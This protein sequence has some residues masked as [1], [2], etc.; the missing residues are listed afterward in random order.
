M[1]WEKNPKRCYMCSKLF[2]KTIRPIPV[3]G[4]NCAPGYIC[5]ACY[6]ELFKRVKTREERN[7]KLKCA[8][9][10]EFGNEE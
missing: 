10:K 6:T 5:L 1:K 9:I 8:E 7:N 2:S 4:G 3:K